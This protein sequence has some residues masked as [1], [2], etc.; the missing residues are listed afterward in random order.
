MTLP[1]T[2]DCSSRQ[3]DSRVSSDDYSEMI[4]EIRCCD[5]WGVGARRTPSGK[6][7]D[8]TI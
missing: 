8:S 4:V 3:L 5:M 6:R 7:R 1:R 2:F